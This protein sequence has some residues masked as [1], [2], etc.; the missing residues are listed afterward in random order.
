MI[1]LPF[2]VFIYFYSVRTQCIYGDDL[3]IFR[4]FSNLKLHGNFKEVISSSQKFR[5]VSFLCTYLIHGAFGKHIMRYFVFNVLVQSLNAI[6]FTAILNRVLRS[7]WLAVLLG[8]CVAFSRFALYNMTQLFCGGT[9]ETLAMT[10]FLLTLFFVVQ[11]IE[12][13]QQGVS[14][15]REMLIAILFSNLAMYTHERY[16]ALFVFLFVV[17]LLYKGGD[18]FNR[19]VVNGTLILGSVLLNIA[20]KKLVLKMDFFVGTGGS[21]ISL[22]AASIF[23]FFSNGVLSILQ[24]NSG[25]EYLVGI[26]HTSLS[27]FWQSVLAVIA[28]GLLVLIVAF[29]KTVIRFREKEQP[30]IQTE[31]CEVAILLF[32]FLL[33]LGPAIITI[34]LE[35][36]WLQA[37]FAVF[38]LLTAM[39]FA[40]LRKRRG[41]ELSVVYSIFIIIF[42][43]SDRNY[44]VQGVQ[45]FYLKDA[46]RSVSMVDNAI[47]SNII[48]PTTEKVYF[49]S[50]LRDENGKN[51]FNWAIGAGYLFEYRESRVREIC[52]V[53][54]AGLTLDSMQVTSMK[55]LDRLKNQIL[56][57]GT[58]VR[59]VTEIVM[60][61][62]Q[63]AFSE[64]VLH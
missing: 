9:L 58:P 55:H 61:R 3:F 21:H 33:C 23:Q 4:D 14:A 18:S 49:Y 34:R 22:S 1:G 16:L 53:D 35:Q 37:S 59:D 19:R 27:F 43:I 7:E 60:D 64:Q 6:I 15:N 12:K 47:D 31:F 48:K 26:P 44:L 46:E 36:R 41:Q 13:L 25:P 10:F 24:I 52:F 28:I 56:E 32:L 57:V 30:F 62:N 45:N 29:I 42:L 20:L 38:I 39:M 50:K 17:L 51:A 54:S 11:Y 5:P 40:T 2:A 8:L 63:K